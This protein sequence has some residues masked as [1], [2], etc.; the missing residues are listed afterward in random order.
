MATDETHKIAAINLNMETPPLKGFSN[1]NKPFL[2]LICIKIITK[3]EEK[4]KLYIIGC[5]VDRDKAVLNFLAEKLGCTGVYSKKEGFESALN[6][7]EVFQSDQGLFFVKMNRVDRLW[8]F[9]AEAVGLKKIEESETVRVPQVFGCGSD[10]RMSFIVMEYIEMMPLRLNSQKDLGEMLAIMHLESGTSQFGFEVEN[11]IGTT[12]QVNSWNPDWVS[13]YSENRLRYQLDRISEK[14]QDERLCKAGRQLIEKLPI[15]FEGLKIRPSLLHGDLWSGNVSVDLEGNPVIYDPAC[16]Y[17]HHE[18]ELSIAK[19]F[20]GFSQDFYDSYHAEIPKASGFEQRKL[21]Y[22]LY[23]YL[24]HYLLFG[25]GY[26]QACFG[27]LQ[28][29]LP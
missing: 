1:L 7:C 10:E 27:I 14:Y 25:G 20:G 11:T 23:H 28:Q 21:I 18:A 29:L 17:G 5:Q 13:F 16:Y 6:H 9:Q 22:Q 12:R 4:I 19:M 26:R 8:M 2:V 24:N 3:N 15:Y